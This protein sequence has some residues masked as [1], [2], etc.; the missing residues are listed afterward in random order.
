[1]E[2]LPSCFCEVRF[3]QPIGGGY[4]AGKWIPQPFPALLTAEQLSLLDEHSQ[5][6]GR[7]PNCEMPITAA[8]ERWKCNHSNEAVTADYGILDK[9]KKLPLLHHADDALMPLELQ[10]VCMRKGIEGQIHE[11]D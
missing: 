10:T 1:M 7:C 5:F 2:F 3:V 4:Y 11:S 6:T 9:L 8:L